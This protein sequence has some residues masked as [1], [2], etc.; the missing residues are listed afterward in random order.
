MELAKKHRTKVLLDG[1]GGDEL[2]GG[3]PHYLSSIFLED[4]H[5]W[6]LASLAKKLRRY[7]FSPLLVG[8]TPV[9]LKKW[10]LGKNLFGVATRFQLGLGLNGRFLRSHS[11]QSRV[12]IDIP[13]TLAEACYRDLM[14]GLQSL[15]RY[16]DKNSMH[17]SVEARVPFLDHEL[18]EF[19]FSLPPDY[20]YGGGGET[21][22][23]LRDTMKKIL[24]RA[25]I[26]RKK[27]GFPT[28]QDE[29]IRSEPMVGCVRSILES[30]SFKNRPYFDSSHCL[31]LFERHV[32]REI[33]IGSVVWR[34]INLES[35]LRASIDPQLKAELRAS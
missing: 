25:I 21:K 28:P 29:W 8:L 35:W 6:R 20:K 3:Y 10:A 31:A 7:G 5:H 1:Q 22:F 16:E 27:L 18:V 2:F 32:R 26:E 14:V 11:Q 19:A 4:L 15:L 13:P 17:F 30:E 12:Q 24:P 33:S 34:W 9:R 23:I